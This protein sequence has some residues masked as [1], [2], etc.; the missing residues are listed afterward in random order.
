MKTGVPV[1][2]VSVLSTMHTKTLLARLR[3]LHQCE[4]SAGG[5]D[6]SADEL[7]DAVGILFKDTPEWTLAYTEVKQAFASREHGPHGG[8][9]RA[10]RLGRGH[11]N[12]TA[13]RRQRLRPMQ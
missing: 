2:E 4:E 10:S 1:L 6:A 9:T 3:R 8:E 5:S 11:A 12:R 13:E 7:A